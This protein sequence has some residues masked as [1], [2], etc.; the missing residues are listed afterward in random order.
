MS[1]CAYALLTL[2]M[3]LAIACTKE[4]SNNPPDNGTPPDVV[5]Q[6][7]GKLPVIPNLLEDSVFIAA[8]VN[9]DSTY[10]LSSRY[11]TTNDTTYKTAGTW[12]VVD[13]SM[14]LTGTKCALKD[15]VVDSLVSIACVVVK[16]PVT[17][18]NNTW[19][20]KLWDLANL[21]VSAGIDTS[22][23]QTKTAMHLIP[24]QLVKQ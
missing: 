12:R 23:S 17:I 4:K 19:N 5:G 22:N 1:R 20:I 15:T 14:V 8:D 13:D 7:L 2:L 24:L 10:S 9:V 16:I 6:W 11:A 3:L 18:S 21:A